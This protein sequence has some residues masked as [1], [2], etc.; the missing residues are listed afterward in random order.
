MKCSLWKEIC[1]SNN[2]A[3]RSTALKLLKPDIS[4]N[5]KFL[6]RMRFPPN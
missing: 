5:L 6:N 3:V 2:A 1:T 4:G